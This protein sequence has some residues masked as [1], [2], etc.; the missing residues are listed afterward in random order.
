MFQADPSLGTDH[1]RNSIE[2]SLSIQ[3]NMW[4]HTSGLAMPTYMVDIPNGG[5]KAAMVPNFQTS[6]QDHK[7]SFK[8][9]DGVTADYISPTEDLMRKPLNIENYVDEW[10]RVTSK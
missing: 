7:R 8:G 3:K 10:K 6:Q 5:G 2:D 9:W 4:G 1:L